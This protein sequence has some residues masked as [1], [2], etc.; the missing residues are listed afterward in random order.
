MLIEMLRDR[1][2]TENGVTIRLFNAGR[3][4]IVTDDLGAMFVSGGDAREVP[5]VIPSDFVNTRELKEPICHGE[6]IPV[7]IANEQG[8]RAA[9][10]NSRQARGRKGKR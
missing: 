4:Y 9:Q 10:P 6:S 7:P 5:Q 2:G 1:A 3:T 8:G